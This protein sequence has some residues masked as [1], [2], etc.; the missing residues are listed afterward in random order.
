MEFPFV[1]NIMVKIGAS[2][3]HDTRTEKSGSAD[4]K[5][6]GRIDKIG[7]FD[8]YTFVT[9]VSL[10]DQVACVIPKQVAN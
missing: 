8:W 4:S 7:V 3:V 5:L 1:E 9:P 6:P 10:P 2:T